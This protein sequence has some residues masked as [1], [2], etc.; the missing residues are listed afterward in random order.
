MEAEPSADGPAVA[1]RRRDEI[2]A[3]AR[4]T[5]A[6][7]GYTNTSMRDIAEASGMLAGSL[8]SHF[9]S[10]SEM[11]RL[12]LEPL[13]DLLVPAQEAAL[14]SEGTGLQRVMRMIHDLLAILVEHDEEMTI[15]HYEWSELAPLED[16]ASVAERSNHFL[17]LWRQA[18]VDGIADGSIRAD[19]DPDTAVRAITA[20]LHAVVD[21]KRFQVL[22]GKASA[23]PDVEG[24]SAQLQS[25]FSS[26]LG[27]QRKR[28]RR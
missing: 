19:V 14:L 16:L 13:L 3:I 22:P 25:I 9:R 11:L 15:L 23:T 20:S 7:R 1:P 5:F 10:K 2:L 21:R 26:G 24:V 17:E 4:A 8:Y 12:I 6:Q 28:G 18:V 27:N